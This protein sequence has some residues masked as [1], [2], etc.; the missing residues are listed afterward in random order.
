VRGLGVSAL[1]ALA[2]AAPAAAGSGWHVAGSGRGT[3][4]LTGDHVEIGAQ[5]DVGGAN[6]T[7]H[8]E[9]QTLPPFVPTNDGGDVVCMRLVDNRALVVW[10]LRE[11]QTTSAL[12]GFVGDFGALYVEDNGPP[13]GGQPVDRMVDFSLRS[14]TAELFC[15]TDLGF[16]FAFLATPLESGN[17]VVTD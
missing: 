12:P 17:F 13:V 3:G 14:A 16:T 2:L 15:D 11:E 10:R 8:G 5:S 7:G 9:V 6:P 4:P 1:L